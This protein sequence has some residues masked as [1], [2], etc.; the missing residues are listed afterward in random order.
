MVLQSSDS[1]E[2]AQ[3]I[4]SLS[5]EE[6]RGLLCLD[7]IRKLASSLSF[8]LVLTFHASVTGLLI[9]FSRASAG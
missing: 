9:C 2:D 4:E 1:L 7:G 6:Q 5:T 8:S 3:S